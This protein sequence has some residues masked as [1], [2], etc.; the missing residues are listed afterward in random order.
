MYLLWWSLFLFVLALLLLWWSSRQRREL[1]LP[2]GDV[3]YADTAAGQALEKALFDPDLNLTGRPD[4][5][6]REA[7]EIIPVEVK[8]GRTPTRPYDSHIYQLAAYCLLVKSH[9]NVRPSH[10]VI[11]YPERSF[12][13]E[14]TNELEQQTRQ[15]V[16]EMRQKTS[17]GE[18]D[19]SHQQA[20]RCRGCGYRQIC[21][22]S[23][24]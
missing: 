5:L 24:I 14:F 11:R 23:L 19:R 12:R 3:L 13:I 10:G 22:Q 20:A 4:Y 9:Y 6:L 21:E 8:S 16:V 15:L 18:L 1:D 2:G 17:Q 7:G